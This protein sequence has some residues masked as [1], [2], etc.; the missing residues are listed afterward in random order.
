[1]LRH[2]NET[3]ARNEV[4]QLYSAD[5]RNGRRDPL[6]AQ[7]LRGPWLLRVAEMLRERAVTFSC[8]CTGEEW[9]EEGAES[10][11]PDVGGQLGGEMGEVAMVSIQLLRF[12]LYESTA[13]YTAQKSG[14]VHGDCDRT[15]PTAEAVE[16]YLEP[17]SY[18]HLTLPTI[19]SV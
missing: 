3:R 16:A 2:I 9:S 15:G 19:Y 10:D 14:S 13:E 12:I 5:W 11:G 8:R 6:W 4:L 1:M 17:V 18:T 7:Q